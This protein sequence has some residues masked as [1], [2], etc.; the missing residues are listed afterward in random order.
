M[1]MNDRLVR[2]ID[3]ITA[4]GSDVSNPAR[5]WTAPFA[6][7]EIIKG[8]DYVLIGSMCKSERA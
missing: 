5:D 2:A 4:N 6:L 8:T 7:R 3:S 1:N